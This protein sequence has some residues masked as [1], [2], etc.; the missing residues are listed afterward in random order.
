MHKERPVAPGSGCCWSL[1]TLQGQTHYVHRVADGK[2]GTNTPAPLPVDGVDMRFKFTTGFQSSQWDSQ[3]T[4]DTPSSLD[5]FPVS[6]ITAS[7]SYF[8]NTLYAPESSQG[9]LLR[10]LSL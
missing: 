1:P 3:C 4:T 8:P 2:R 9:Q 10:R 7:W 5:A 6:P